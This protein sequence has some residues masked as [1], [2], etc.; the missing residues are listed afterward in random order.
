[1]EVH[2]V[3]SLRGSKR[4]AAWQGLVLSPCKVSLPCGSIT[5]LLAKYMANAC[6]RKLKALRQDGLQV[7]DWQ[8]QSDHIRAGCL[9]AC[10]ACYGGGTAG[11]EQTIVLLSEAAGTAQPAQP[12]RCARQLDRPSHTPS[13]D[14]GISGLLPYAALD[15]RE[16]GPQAEASKQAPALRPW[17]SLGALQTFVSQSGCWTAR[18]EKAHS[19]H[20][21]LQDVK[22]HHTFTLKW[23]G[24]RSRG[25]ASDGGLALC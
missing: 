8:P 17:S 16:A 25:D 9:G 22:R 14:S 12:L 13:L 24:K 5:A 23:T 2:I 18:Q 3:S 21:L 4:S 7:S 1:M 15:D 6:R 10:A 11:D 19:L 20:I